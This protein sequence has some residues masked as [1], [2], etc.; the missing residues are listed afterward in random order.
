LSVFYS[1]NISFSPSFYLPSSILLLP[2]FH[3]LFYFLPP[4]SLSLS[5]DFVILKNSSRQMPQ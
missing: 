4:L 2:F 5:I 3:S 1:Y